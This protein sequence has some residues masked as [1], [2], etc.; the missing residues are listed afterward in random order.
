[1]RQFISWLCLACFVIGFALQVRDYRR[2]PGQDKDRA[3]IGLTLN[4]VAGFLLFSLLI[5]G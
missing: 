5:W 4:A 1:M 2:K 3:L